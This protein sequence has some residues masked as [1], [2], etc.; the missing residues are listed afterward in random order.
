V[1][2]PAGRRHGPTVTIGCIYPMAGRAAR[3][4]HDSM[5]AAEMAAEEINEAAGV[6]GHEVRLLCADERSDPTAAVKAAVRYI[7]EDRADFLMGVYSSAVAMA[8]SAVARELRTVLV[9]T[10]HAS[11][12]LS[13]EDF[14]AYYF[15]VHNNTLQCM[16]AGAIFAS[17][18]SWGTVLWIAADYEYG[19]RQS[20]EFRGF[21]SQ[22]RPDMRF[23]PDLWPRLFERDYGPYLDAI[24][25]AMPDVV[26]HGFSGGDAVAFT[27]QAQARGLFHE[28]PMAS[29]DA[30]GDYPVFEALGDQMPAGL[31]LGTRHHLNFPETELN[32]RFVRRFH[33]RAARYP[34]QAALGAYIGVQFIAAA[35]AKAGA[36]GDASAFIAAA[37]GLRLRTPKDRDGFTSW[38]RPIDHQMVQE[39]VIGV[40]QRDDRFPPARYALGQWTVIEAERIVP[41]EAEVRQARRRR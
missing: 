17:Q 19:H 15:R 37:E 2:A 18:Q 21:L 30:G 5:I 26:V 20:V 8:V 31:I 38:M 24:K 1:K 7:E 6:L 27:Q 12:R 28:V 40:S 9:G 35:L 32:R 10:E 33:E 14:H 34:S 16:R 29:F 3:L 22:L 39:H 25:R 36:V 41:S 4:G 13:L 23:L 11:S